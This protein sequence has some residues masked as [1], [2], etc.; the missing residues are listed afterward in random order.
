MSYSFTATA[1]TKQEAKDLI[2]SNFEN[3]VA[4]QGVHAADRS[5]AVACGQAFVD[6]LTAEPGDNE[7]IHVSMYGSLG[8]RGTYLYVASVNVNVAIR[9]KG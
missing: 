8:W 4:S 3:V 1:S 9:T 7:E 6:V 2:A 5:A